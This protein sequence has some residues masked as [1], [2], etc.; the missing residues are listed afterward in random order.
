MLNVT[1]LSADYAPR[2]LELMRNTVARDCS[3]EEFN[4]FVAA[5]RRAGL[6][7]F[8]RQISAIVFSKGN[9]EKRRMAI[10]TTIDGLRSIAGRSLRYRPD[11]QEPSFAYDAE[12]KGPTNPLGIDRVMVRV[13]IRD[14]GGNEWHPV[15]GVAYWSE[16]AP[17]ADE[18]VDDERTGKRKPSGRQYLDPKSQWAKMPRLM[19]AKCAEAVALRRAFPEDLSGLY[20][21]SELDRAQLAEAVLPS[22]VVEAEATQQRLERIGAGGRTIT[23]Q[24]HP[25]EPLVQV[26]V[27]QVADRAI[28]AY[29]A[30]DVRQKAWFESV[31]RAGLQEFWALSPTDALGLKTEME[32]LRSQEPEGVTP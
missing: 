13:Y 1:P 7:P 23:F 26:P 8:R 25:V 29:R 2:Q 9:A 3:S 30:L 11:D 12:L 4:L 18:W 20:E 28:E 16:F 5:A 6:D 10:I 31:N 24:F 19:L 27:G 32:R 21:A 15:V 14:Q 22:E 17:V